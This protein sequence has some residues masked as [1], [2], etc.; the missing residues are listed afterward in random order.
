MEHVHIS[1]LSVIV[2]GLSA[3]V[4][5]GSLTVLAKNN[6]KHPASQAWLDIFGPGC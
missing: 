3:V 2:A 4:V 6:P 5:I 1:A